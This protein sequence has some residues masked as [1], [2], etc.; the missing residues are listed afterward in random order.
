MAPLPE[1]MLV[2]APETIG[3]LA[4]ID[5]QYYSLIQ[6]AIEEQLTH[7][8]STPTRNRKQL[9]QPAPYGAR[10]EIRF[11][12]NNQFRVFYR[13]IE[14][15]MTVRILAIGVKRTN[16]LYIGDEEFI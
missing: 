11:G 8:P 1:Y 4:A 9:R 16:K 14:T 10:W 13:I 6:E 7:T 12:P 3:H 5:R 2:F 15:E